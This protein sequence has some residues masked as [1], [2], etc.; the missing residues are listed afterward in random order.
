M[1]NPLKTN[2]IRKKMEV[3][4]NNLT[5]AEKV[6]EAKRLIC[7][8]CVHEQCGTSAC[9]LESATWEDLLNFYNRR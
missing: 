6:A 5:D 9:Y 7:K 4:K 2:K 3:H 1:R 8:M